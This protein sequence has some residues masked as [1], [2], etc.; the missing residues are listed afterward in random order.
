MIF[1]QCMRKQTL[2]CSVN[3]D[4][5]KKFGKKIQNTLLTSDFEIQLD[6]FKVSFGVSPYGNIAKT[7][8]TLWFC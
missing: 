1:T 3:V 2:K 5:Y 7:V 8:K 4:T 6:C